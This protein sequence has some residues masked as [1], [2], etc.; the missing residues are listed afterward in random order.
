L[1]TALAIVGSA[2]AL[3]DQPLDHA[4]FIPPEGSERVPPGSQVA[5]VVYGDFGIDFEMFVDADGDELPGPLRVSKRFQ[6]ERPDP[7]GFFVWHPY[8]P[9]DT[10]SLHTIHLLHSGKEVASSTFE[11]AEE[12]IRVLSTIPLVTIQN[13]SGVKERDDACGARSVRDVSLEI[14][15]ADNDPLASSYLELHLFP[16]GGGVNDETIYDVIPV[17]TDDSPIEMTIEV[18]DDQAADYCLTAFQVSAGGQESGV[19]E[20][21][22]WVNDNFAAGCDSG[23]GWVQA[24]P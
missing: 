4:V 22:A 13:V 19:S 10:N 24:R 12:T 21:Y 1:L 2:H 15:P 6:A 18:P 7:G 3:C 9:F 17:P 5:V 14:Y 11:A 23:C 20:P 8:T 16:T